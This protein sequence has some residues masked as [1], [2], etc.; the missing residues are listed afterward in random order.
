[1]KRFIRLFMCFAV[2]LGA[3]PFI[4]MKTTTAAAEYVVAPRIA[5]GYYHSLVLVT[6][7]T[8]YGW[9]QN[10]EGQLGIGTISG[11]NVPV[12]VKN[13]D[14]V[15]SIATGIRSSYAIKE[16]GTLWAWGMNGNGQLGD[17]TTITRT[18]PV[19]ITGIPSGV[20]SLS[21]G[22]GYHTLA[23]DNDGNVWAWGTNSGGELGDGTTIQRNSP[24]KI[25]G[26]DDVVA[27]AAGGWHSLAVKSDGTVWTWGNNEYGEL[28]DGTKIS[29]S[30]PQQIG[31][32]GVK[33]VSAGNNHSLAVKEDGTVW[34]WGRNTWGMLGDS[35]G[36]D[37]LTPVQTSLVSD[38]KAVVGG[39]NHSYAVTNGGKVWAWGVN[40]QGQIGD[41][42]WE[43]RYTPVEITTL[44]DI[45]MLGAGGFNGIAMEKDGTVWVWGFNASGELGDGTAE[46][47]RIPVINKSVADLTSPTIVDPAITAADITQTAVTLSWTPATDNLSKQNELEYRIYR[48]AS[49][50]PGTVSAIESSGTPLGAYEAN[51]NTKQITGLF[52]GQ[53][54]H[55]AILV[56]DK[57]GKKSAYQKKTVKML[58]VPTYVVIYE[59]NGETGGEPPIDSY[60]YWVDEMA[61]VLGN[62]DALEK[63]GF[64]FGGWNTQRDG[65]GTDYAAGSTLIMPASDVVL[66]AKW[67]P[68]PDTTAPT[69]NAYSP[70][71]DAADVPVHKPLTLGF[72]ED[73][74]PVAGKYIIVKNSD[75]SL[76]ET[77]A[78]TDTN[79]VTVSG[80]TVTISPT[81]PWNRSSDYVVRIEP[82]AFADEAGNAYAG[83]SDDT[84]WRFSS[85]AEAVVPGDD[86][87]LGSLSLKSNNNVL[88]GLDPLFARE[89]SS[90][91]VNVAYDVTSV[92]VTAATY[93]SRASVTASVYGSSNDPTK[94]PILLNGGQPSEQLQLVEGINRI[95]LGV[96]AED[97]TSNK[98]TISVTRATAPSVPG[99][100]PGT[101]SGSGPGSAPE[102][103]AEP[104]T[105]VSIS[106]QALKGLVSERSVVENGSNRLILT[107]NTAAFLERL[108]KEKETP[109]IVIASETPGSN[110]VVL[111]LTGDVV[112]A[113]GAKEAILEIRTANGSYRLPAALVPID[114]LTGR[115]GA[116]GDTAK[117]TF[118]IEITQLGVA[119][120]ANLR[121][122]GSPVEF[123]I[124]AAYGA[125]EAELDK[126]GA[127]VERTIPI[128]AGAGADRITTAVVLEADGSVRHVPTLIAD[129]DGKSVAVIRSLTNS[130]YALIWHPVAFGD[131]EGHWSQAEVNDLASRMV[132]SG[133]RGDR[134]DPSAAITRAEFTAI[135][136]RALGLSDQG[137]AARF[138]DVPS[139]AWYLG[140]VGKALEYG[141]VKGGT[142]DR[143]NPD[144]AITRE[145][146]ASMIASAMR[147]TGLS[148]DLDDSA[149]ATALAPFEDRDSVS[150]WAKEAMAAAIDK[151]LLKGNDSKLMPKSSITRAET[152]ILVH[153]LLEKS[154]FINSN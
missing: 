112:Q 35:T 7:G 146:A 144:Q 75:G 49:S 53:T 136:V 111:E 129:R 8:V 69:V 86:A 23:I 1:M 83:I 10:T 48:V 103:P 6:D 62:T 66:F 77:I 54:Y 59:G 140:A 34:S 42:T 31:I 60:E 141:I 72:D 45:E 76:F 151:G 133:K 142:G 43:W 98:Y 99:T 101:G 5:T 22:I 74:T 78:A 2:L 80:S 113:L 122:I 71:Q 33:S 51:I 37:R 64:T 81:V 145:E 39:G 40:T 65:K 110:A 19:Q 26:L 16:D 108:A 79:K 36:Y 143:F 116:A 87:T 67:I 147:L 109:S 91:R 152:A 120:F 139:G 105:K 11:K 153:R 12:K 63:T 14:R 73:V 121:L 47:R 131:V 134:Y 149:T 15:K 115:F 20:K 100:N 57:A 9:G 29:R 28:G 50:N 119:E 55:F 117:V 95:E 44:S 89:T 92:S 84:T 137:E 106:G 104:S 3:I 126:F 18:E 96:R 61:E 118:R 88:I 52:G 17:G 132:V 46:E 21:T 90:Y 125:R 82:G 27:V 41:G 13:L 102:A 56:K 68:G 123:R 58:P 130:K 114:S 30:T 138:K 24:V 127:Y 107:V 70:L 135:L 124:T 38:V 128:S 148:A 97:G 85:A 93:D 154:K 32:S 150:G 4:Q 94:G 25:A